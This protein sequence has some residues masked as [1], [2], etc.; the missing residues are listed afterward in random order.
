[1]I[2]MSPGPNGAP[3]ADLHAEPEQFSHGLDQANKV[4]L[5]GGWK[6][7]TPRRGSQP[8]Q[9]SSKLELAGTRF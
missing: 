4:V 2:L 9:K 3:D 5:G 6:P 7:A 1:L 8:M